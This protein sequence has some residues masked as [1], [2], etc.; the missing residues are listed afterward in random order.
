MFR[1]VLFGPNTVRVVSPPQPILTGQLANSTKI[2]RFA[3]LLRA[4]IVEK[5]GMMNLVVFGDNLIGKSVK[6]LCIAREGF[7]DTE[8]SPGCISDLVLSVVPCVVDSPAKQREDVISLEFLIST[9]QNQF[10]DPK[11]Q[12]VELSVSSNMD[13]ETLARKL[14]A[15]YLKKSADSF[16]LRCMGYSSAATIVKA[17]GLFNQRV[18]S[19][20][21][22]AAIRTESVPDSY[23]RGSN[24][25]SDRSLRAI[26]FEVVVLDNT[27]D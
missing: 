13:Y 14:H 21:L 1:R 4:E 3:K 5:R 19:H 16:V 8:T 15:M 22:H 17:L 10:A 18:D 6:A 9:R 27:S 20:K 12:P 23:M 11:S 26:V 2:G 24:K 7:H 25:P